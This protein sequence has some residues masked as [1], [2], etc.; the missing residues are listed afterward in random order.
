MKKTFRP[1]IIAP[2]EGVAPLPDLKRPRREPQR[3]AS[4]MKIVALVAALAILALLL[5]S[6]WLHRHRDKFA[7]P[8][9]SRLLSRFLEANLLSVQCPYCRG[10]G[11]SPD[12]PGTSEADI[13]PVC[14]GL[15]SHYLRITDETEFICPHCQGMGRRPDAAGR[16]VECDHCGGR[17]IVKGVPARGVDGQP[18]RILQIECDECLGHGFVRDPQTDRTKTC[19]VCFGLGYHWV[20]KTDDTPN[21]CPACGGMGRI[22]DPETRRSR[23]CER[24]GGRGLTAAEPSKST[25]SER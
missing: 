24:C 3:P 10:S 19:P 17:G 4:H 13:C 22:L 18:M 15:G 16:I 1:A 7:D 5:Q 23:V 12:G 8:A 6:H 2:R 21:I 20:R 11:L 25:E 14:F 9:V